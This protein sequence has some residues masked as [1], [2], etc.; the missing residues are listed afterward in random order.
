M[1]PSEGGYPF[2]SMTTTALGLGTTRNSQ[3]SSYRLNTAQIG[4]QK[5]KCLPMDR[6][7]VEIRTFEL[8]MNPPGSQG[9]LNQRMP[10]EI[11]NIT[12]PH[13]VTSHSEFS[14]GLKRGKT[15]T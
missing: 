7:R 9:N 4:R 5:I 13:Q 12:Y 1:K 14:L 8:K 15:S 11:C 10:E 6:V 2:S 3:G